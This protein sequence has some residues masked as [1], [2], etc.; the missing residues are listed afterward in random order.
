MHMFTFNSLNNNSNPFLKKPANSFYTKSTVG[1][2]A[3]TINRV[4]QS[5]L[6]AANSY[7]A[8]NGLIFMKTSW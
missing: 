1:F 8:N 2:N 6:L 4:N 3:K 7:P 5:R